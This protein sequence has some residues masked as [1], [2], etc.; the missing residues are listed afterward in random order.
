VIGEVLVV[1]G[2]VNLGFDGA[3]EI[4]DFLGAFIDEEDDEV[5]IGMVFDDS[6]GDIVQEGGFASAGRGDDEATGAFARWGKRGP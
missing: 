1:R 3:L 5:A 2:G 6:V 4:G